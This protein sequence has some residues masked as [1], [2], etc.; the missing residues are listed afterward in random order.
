MCANQ[1]S[2]EAKPT[3]LAPETKSKID[4]ASLTDDECRELVSRIHE[5]LGEVCFTWSI[6]R[7]IE[8]VPYLSRDQA[9][10]VLIRFQPADPWDDIDALLEW[11]LDNDDEFMYSLHFGTSLD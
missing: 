6:D 9:R 2:N 3:D 10:Y 5:R 7:L 4:I 8:R 11:L 1:N